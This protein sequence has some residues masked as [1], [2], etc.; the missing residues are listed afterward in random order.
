MNSYS[1]ANTTALT[2]DTLRS[3][4][5]A[6]YAHAAHP[7]TTAAYTFISTERVLEGLQQAGFIP[8]DVRQTRTRRTSPLHAR[9]AI[10]LRRRYETVQLR[11]SIPELLFINSHDGTA[12]YQLRVG[13]FRVVCTNGLIVSVGLFPTFRVTHRGD[14]VEDVVQGALQISERFTHLADH[15]ELMEHRVL[16]DSERFRFAERALALR[17]PTPMEHGMQ[18]SQL[19]KCRRYE[20]QGHDL[21]HTL[22]VIQENLLR[23][24]LTR[25]TAAG[26]MTRT[27]AITGLKEDLRLNTA[28]WA[29]ATEYLTT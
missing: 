16:G 7:K 13:L 25:W 5:P 24:G 1:T 17:Y 14:V 21:W 11:D 19:L 8:V 23:G 29:L 6:I 12:A 20:D 18:P 3:N 4:A 26:R 2:A 10:R 28:L 22:N 9:H 27:R 15:V